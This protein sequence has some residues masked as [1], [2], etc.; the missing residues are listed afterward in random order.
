MTTANALPLCD[1]IHTAK[2]DEFLTLKPAIELHAQ[3][4]FRHL[5]AADR[6]EAIAEA[7]AAA[8]QSFASLTNRGKDPSQFPSM[9]AT[10]AVQHVYNCRRVGTPLNSDDVFSRLARR[11]DGFQLHSLHR[12]EGDWMEALVDDTQTPVPDQVSFRCDFPGWLRTLT[13]R[14]CRLVN[15]LAMGHSTNLM[16]KLF[17]LS[18]ARISQLR[19]EMHEWWQMF[20]GEPEESEAC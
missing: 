13:A 16:A 7:V 5:P 10:R 1:R 2:A 14:D 8:F 3:V 9:L 6:E 12:E 19:H 11:R 18:P 4:A 15:L 17:G 20:L